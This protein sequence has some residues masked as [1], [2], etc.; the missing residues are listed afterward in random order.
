VHLAC[1]A[2][3]THMHTGDRPADAIDAG[4]VLPGY[5][6]IL[7]RDGCHTGYGHLTD[8]LRAW[9][10]AH[11]LRGLKD[12]YESELGKQDRAQQMAAL[13][14]E[15]RDA[16]RSARAEGNKALDQDV[17][18]G[19]AGRYRAIAASGLAASLCRQTATAKDACRIARR[20]IKYEDM[21]LR[22]I[23]RPGPDIFTNNQAGQTIR[24]VKVQQRSSGG[25]WRTLDGLAEFAIVQSCLSTASKWGISKPDAPAASSTAPPGCH[26]DPNPNPADNT[27]NYPCHS[28]PSD[29]C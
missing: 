5:A 3:L 19:L 4:G 9:C 13:L 15:G 6:G 10:G 18:A 14:I 23:T 25:S 20:F 27:L 2:F 1:T 12:L 21:I 8:A 26:P 28:K 7:V 16:A 22:F 11:L 17:P 29:A 24:P